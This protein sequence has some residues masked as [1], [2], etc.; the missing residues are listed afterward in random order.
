MGMTEQELNQSSIQYLVRRINGFRSAQKQDR[1]FQLT[2]YRELCYY[3]AN[4]GNFKNGIK[5]TQLF[6]IPGEKELERTKYLEEL[7]EGIEVMKRWP[8]PKGIA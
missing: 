6:S 8:K 1:I 2:M 7:M 3:A 4:G 5:R